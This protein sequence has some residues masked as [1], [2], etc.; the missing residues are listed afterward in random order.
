MGCCIKKALCL[1][2]RVSDPPVAVGK[3]RENCEMLAIMK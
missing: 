2:P 3:R 1:T